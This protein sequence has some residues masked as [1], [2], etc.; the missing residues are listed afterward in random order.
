MRWKW[1]TISCNSY[2]ALLSDLYSLKLILR[3]A[4][5]L[6]FITDPRKISSKTSAV[7]FERC[8]KVCN[9]EWLLL[10]TDI[11]SLHYRLSLR[12]CRMRLSPR[13]V[14]LTLFA[15]LLLLA[16][17]SLTSRLPQALE[18][19]YGGVMGSLR[20]RAEFSVQPKD[21][22]TIVMQTY[23]RTD[24]LLKLLNHYQA[25]PHL[26]QI[27]IVW[28]NI[29]ERP[30]QQMWDSLGPHP[31]PVFFKEQTLNLMRN[32][33]LP[34]SEIDTEGITNYFNCLG[35]GGRCCSRLW[36]RL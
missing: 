29:G 35:G 4:T 31:V 25:V 16:G 18:T 22:F 14:F 2:N 32:R 23:N 15:L 24:I 10:T 36:A 8:I 5:K 26:K 30:P 12:S 11:I 28:N 27:V 6:T 33:L 9:V 20:R 1:G 17:A 21:S 34:F 3:L 13:K 19:D 7:N